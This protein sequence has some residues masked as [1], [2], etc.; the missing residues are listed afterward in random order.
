[1][2][3]PQSNTAPPNGCVNYYQPKRIITVN[4]SSARLTD[5]DNTLHDASILAKQSPAGV[6]FPNAN[7]VIAKG[8]TFH[9]DSTDTKWLKISQR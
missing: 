2:S 5:I 4:C 3:S 9:I 6:W 8:A 7:L 1:M